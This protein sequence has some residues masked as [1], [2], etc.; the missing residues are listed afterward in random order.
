MSDVLEIKFL[1]QTYRFRSGDD[2]VDAREVASYV[3]SRLCEV[4]QKYPGLSPG[5]IMVMAALHMGKDYIQMKQRLDSV[6]EG[7]KRQSELIEE[8][9]A[10]FQL[11]NE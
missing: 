10:V 7:I 11:E 4:E 5:K 8:K 3:E 2:S 6:Q 9:L 1:G